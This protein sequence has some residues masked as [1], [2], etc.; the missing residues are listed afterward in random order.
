MKYQIICCDPPYG[1]S[2][3]LKM[4]SVKRGAAAN[5]STMSIDD[6]CAL[7]IKD[8]VDPNGAILALWV[9]SSMISD[10]LKIMSAWGF[11]QK[12]SYVWVKTKLDISIYHLLKDGFLP[13]KDIPSK[14]K[15]VYDNL[16]SMGM[17]RLFRNSHEICLIGTN[18]N[19]IYKK[20][21]NHSQRSV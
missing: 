15:Y 17:G 21:E 12:Q 8:I 13:L 3:G 7:P 9:P 16:M 11:Q 4:S 2:D 1:F 5:Y 19:G 14:V 6:L 18:S 10:G 20:L